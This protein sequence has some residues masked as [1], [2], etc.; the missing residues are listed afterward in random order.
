[1]LTAAM[2]KK[3]LDSPVL[4]EGVHDR[5][6]QDA[7]AV[8]RRAGIPLTML[9][10]SATTYCN[11]DELEYTKQLTQHSVENVFGFLYTGKK[12]ALGT[13]PVSMR[14]MALAGACV[15]NFIDARVMT[16]QDVLSGLKKDLQ[17]SATVLLIP[18]FF[19]SKEQGGNIPS[20]QVAGLLSLL[21]N[22]MASGQQTFLYVEDIDDMAMQYGDAFREHLNN[23]FRRAE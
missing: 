14:M 4:M 11:D 5:L 16:V 22:R 10:T 8:A 18:N 9:W 12:F 23:Y 6:L 20:W 13:H 19:I 15:R 17:P 7:E 21:F 1:M 2:Q 3:A